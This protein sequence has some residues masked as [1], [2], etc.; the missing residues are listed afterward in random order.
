MAIGWCPACCWSAETATVL[1]RSRQQTEGYAERPIGPTRW[2]DQTRFT[3]TARRPAIAQPACARPGRRHRPRYDGAL[4]I[5]DRPAGCAGDRRE[6]IDVDRHP[7]E[8]R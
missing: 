5:H 6:C 8:G 7:A 1:E 4:A 3:W 2:P